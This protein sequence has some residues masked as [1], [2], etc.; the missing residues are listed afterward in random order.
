MALTRYGVAWS[1]WATHPRCPT[2]RVSYAEAR[3]LFGR[4]TAKGGRGGWLADASIPEPATTIASRPAARTP[5]RHPG[6]PPEETASRAS[7]LAAFT[8]SLRE[9][10][11]RTYASPCA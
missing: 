10:E 11:R 2:R 1:P 4:P 7:R 5:P 3:F 8:G 6:P 9:E